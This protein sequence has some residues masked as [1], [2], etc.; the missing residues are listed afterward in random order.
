VIKWTQAELEEMDRSTRKLLTIHRGSAMKS[1]VNRLYTSRS[2]GGRGLV[3]VSDCIK[4]EEASL[5][6]SSRKNMQVIIRK[7]A[8]DNPDP[9]LVKEEIQKLR[10][11]GWGT[12][13]MHGQYLRQLLDNERL[14]KKL[15]FKWLSRGEMSI[16]T[17]GF[18]CAAQEQA[19][20]TRAIGNHIYKTVGSD[21][22]RVC[23]NSCETV[24]H[25]VAECSSIAQSEYLE[26]HN[27][28]AKYVHF[29]LLQAHRGQ[30]VKWYEHE[31]QKVFE[32]ESTK[33][34][35]DFN[36]YTDKKIPARR[37]DIVVINKKQGS[38]YI[39]DVNCPNDR[40][41][42]KNEI[43]K[44]VKYTDLKIELERIWNIHFQVIPIVIGALGA[45]SKRILT[46]AATL[47]LDEDDIGRLQ[48]EVIHSTC[49]I[50]RKYVTQ[51]GLAL[52]Q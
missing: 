6:Q 30:E 34:L 22:C 39:I 47:G 38:G 29:K 33:I 28:V 5:K 43:E 35:W 42:V 18:L 13:V 31:P 52:T 11:E 24:M 25:I 10:Q 50:L 44:I 48:S 2:E 46:F 1:D 37:P 15:T 14:D 26:R 40:N 41:V 19:I 49:H 9:K 8:P 4:I 7:V 16:E 12:K 21:K 32:T 51:S 20:H 23:G 17:E 45:M 3:S 27:K 36:I